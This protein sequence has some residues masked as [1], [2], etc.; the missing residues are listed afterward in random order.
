MVR[1][2]VVPALLISFSLVAQSPTPAELKRLTLN[3]ALQVALENNL[4]VGI[5]KAARENTQANVT[6]N[7]GT[8]DWNLA[9]TASVKRFDSVA[10][11]VTYTPLGTTY[12]G[13]SI[14]DTYQRDFT[15]D[16]TK[17]F[18]WGGSVD[19]NY[20]P[21]YTYSR[22]TVE[23]L[24]GAQ[25]GGNLIPTTTSNTS[26]P[27]S[28]SFTAT[29]TQ[30]LLKGFG[31]SVT[32]ANLVVARKTS[33]ASDYTFQQA[34]ITLVSTTEGQYWDVVFANRNLA[35]MT[36]SLKLAKQQLDENVIRVKVG[37]M[38][39]IEVTSAEAQVA[40]AEQNIIAAEAQV[41]NAR[42]ALLRALYPDRPQT[43]I[44][45]PTDSP[46]IAHIQVDETAA[47]KMALDR[48]VELKG[49]AIGKEV[50]RIQESVAVDKVRPQLDAF[51]AYNGA[52]DSYG[53]LGPVNTDLS[54]TKY[55]GYTVG[56]KFS[57]P[58]QNRAAKGNLSMA[59][60]NTRS[61]ELNLRD[62]QLSIA[63]EART[64]ARNVAS[65][66]K[67]V[68][69]SA[70]T[71]FYQEANLDAERKKFENGMSTNFTVLQIMTNLDNAKSA[72]LTAQIN[73][74]KAA[75]ALEVAVGN[76]MEARH[77]TVK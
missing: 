59:R 31:T 26:M 46:D 73:Y 40:Q 61:S 35:N 65:A 2:S 63:L 48:R 30:S 18:E 4:Q 28:G 3:E 36:T 67:A 42:D 1:T 32:T 49:L 74:A 38:A 23:N 75:T 27:Y 10:S 11:G 17:T 41:N 25:E 68:K 29:Y 56:L 14:N 15:A 8:F 43:A 50:A 72:E 19:L 51:V 54:G 6:V 77:F 53:A 13:H 21:A 71:R 52:S 58:L 64:A 55:P 12:L 45:E 5:A 16:L 34:L 47:V 70:K 9:A 69:A 37:T 66:E 20:S 62:K 22:S 24:R 44:L 39:P 57:V 60:A 7:E 33:E 76:L